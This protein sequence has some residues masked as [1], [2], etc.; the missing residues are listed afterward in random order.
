MWLASMFFVVMLSSVVVK[1]LVLTCA[2]D[3][4]LQLWQRSV[5][6]LRRS[7]QA[8]VPQSAAG[9]GESTTSEEYSPSEEPPSRGAPDA[10]SPGI[11]TGVPRR[12]LSSIPVTAPPFLFGSMPYTN[13]GMQP[14]YTP[15]SQG[16]SMVAYLP[17]GPH[18][19]DPATRRLTPISQPTSLGTQQVCPPWQATLHCC[20]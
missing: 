10:I 4:S 13:Y 14:Y 3:T 6:A 20:R 11:Y 1:V 16:S 17:S 18:H 8:A 15:Q 2:G 7:S 9:M 12:Q 19:W 5:R